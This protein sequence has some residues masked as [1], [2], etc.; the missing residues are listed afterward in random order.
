MF[1]VTWQIGSSSKF[2]E[3]V[4]QHFQHLLLNTTVYV[5]DARLFLFLMTRPRCLWPRRPLSGYFLSLFIIIHIHWETFL[6]KG[7]EIWHTK[8]VTG[9]WQKCISFE[10]VHIHTKPH[11]KQVYGKV[12]YFCQSTLPRTDLGDAGMVGQH[13][14]ADSMG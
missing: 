7:S 5:S 2:V 9:A 13:E 6:P 8:L 12:Y 3:N 1:T 4:F 11:I 10:I 14:A